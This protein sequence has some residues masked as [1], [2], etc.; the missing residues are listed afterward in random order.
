MRNILKQL[1]LFVE[2]AIVRFLFLL[3]S[4]LPINLVSKLGGCIVKLIGPMFQSHQVALSNFK[5]IYTDLNNHQI[6]IKV[7]KS[8]KNLGKTIF[9]LSILEKLIDK[10]NNKI[11]IKGLE[12]IKNIIDNSEQVIF[13]SIHQSNWEI[14]VPVIDQLGISVGAIYRHI[15]NKYIDRL[16]LKKRNQSINSKRSF[17]TPKGKESAKELIFCN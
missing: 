8:W 17:Y 16:V 3:L 9:E 4:F 14:L 13:F 10:K 11:T 1:R 12:N 2:Y 6:R 5:K 15:N 7:N